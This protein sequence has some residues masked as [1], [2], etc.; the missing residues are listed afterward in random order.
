MEISINPPTFNKRKSY[1]NFRQELLAWS[2]ITDISK[3]KQG[4]VIALSLSENDETQISDKIFD[5]ISIYDLKSDDGLR[6]LLN[7]LD[8]HLGKDD[9]TDILD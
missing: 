2:E 4:I 8:Q 3:S 7:F 6:I 5:K 1:E 9:L